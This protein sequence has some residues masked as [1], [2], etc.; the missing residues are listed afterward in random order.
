M[1]E[2]LVVGKLLERPMERKSKKG[3]SFVTARLRASFGKGDTVYV[4]AIAFDEAP[5]TA[6]KAMDANEALALTGSLS[7]KAWISPEGEGRAG[8]EITVTHVLTPYHV[9]RKRASM[10]NPPNAPLPST[11]AVS[12][13]LFGEDLGSNERLDF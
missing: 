3:R 2:G 13:Q 12:G 9:K 1:I 11:A 8:L 7:P 10:W 6:L 5:C 4:D